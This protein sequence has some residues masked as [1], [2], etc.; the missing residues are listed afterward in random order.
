M[1]KLPTPSSWDRS[2]SH[3]R[4]SRSGCNQMQCVCYNCQ[5]ISKHRVLHWLT[6]ALPCLQSC[7]LLSPNAQLWLNNTVQTAAQQDATGG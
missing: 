3:L 7:C 2:P 1:T 5:A 6:K 4:R